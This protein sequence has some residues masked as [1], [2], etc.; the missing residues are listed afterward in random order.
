MIV[1]ISKLSNQRFS[2]GGF[3]QWREYFWSFSQRV[4]LR[5]VR[6]SMF[7]TISGAGFRF[8]GSFGAECTASRPQRTLGVE[9]GNTASRTGAVQEPGLGTGGQ[10]VS[11]AGSQAA[12]R[13]PGHPGR[14]PAH[15]FVKIHSDFGENVRHSIWL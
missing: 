15:P 12:G 5:I 3:S 13:A 14:T 9:T 6:F 11:R 4:E 10:P 8:S 7:L 2:S 1:K